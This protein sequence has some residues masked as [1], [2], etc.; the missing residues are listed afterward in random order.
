LS[1][2]TGGIQMDISG[3]GW[4]ELPA[5]PSSET[6]AVATLPYYAHCLDCFGAERCMFESNFPMDKKSGSYHTI[7]NM[8]KRV[9]QMHGKY[10]LRFLHS[11]LHL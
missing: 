3:F 8:F 6:M 2:G 4:D 5:P 7:W 1:S 9:A 10:A 11:Q